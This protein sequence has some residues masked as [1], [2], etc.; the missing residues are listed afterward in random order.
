M[1]STPIAAPVLMIHA[2]RLPMTMGMR[3]MRMRMGMPMR[4]PSDRRTRSAAHGD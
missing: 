2:M 3:P 1:K 4:I